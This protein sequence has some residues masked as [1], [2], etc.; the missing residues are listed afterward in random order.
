MWL[1]QVAV[2][3]PVIWSDGRHGTCRL[4]TYYRCLSGTWICQLV[5]LPIS[6]LDLRF[7]ILHTADDAF[8]ISAKT[9]AQCKEPHCRGQ[10][11][12]LSWH[13]ALFAW[14]DGRLRARRQPRSGESRGREPTGG[15][16]NRIASPEGVTR[17]L[18]RRSRVAPT[19]LGGAAWLRFP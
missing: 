19:G 17:I 15:G 14:A 12:D 13:R 2:Q 4:R 8:G 16:A 1:R 11:S 7:Q 18:A 3:G 10:Q 6:L 5:D 9:A